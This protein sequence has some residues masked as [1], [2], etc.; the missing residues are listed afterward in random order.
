MKSFTEYQIKF[1]PFNADLVTGVLWTLEIEGIVENEDSISVYSDSEK[2]EI[3]RELEDLLE[4]LVKEGVIERYLISSSDVEN[5]NWNEEWEKG[6]KVIEISDRITIKPTFRE[7]E[8]TSG[9]IVI[10]IDPKM[11]FGTGEHQTTR[12]M[13]GFLEKYVNGGE[14][15]L[16]VGSGT[17]V[18]SI[19][20][21]LLGA[22]SAVAFDIDEWAFE[23][24][25]EN[26]RLN[27]LEGKIEIRKA[28]ITEIPEMDFDLV[29]ANINTHIILSVMNSLAE[30]V[31]QGGY[32]FLSGLLN[33]DEEKLIEVFKNLAFEFIEKKRGRDWSG[34]VFRKKN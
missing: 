4:S 24:G 30:K 12:I 3:K 34:L 27:G 16:D 8:N 7:Y 31:K 26:V 18:L 28:E 23:N 2:K 19:A 21:I 22:E 29:L 13:L 32:L 6:L 10:E 5:R 33:S 11:S 20:S 17:A 25:I 14:K 9:K 15:I 1:L